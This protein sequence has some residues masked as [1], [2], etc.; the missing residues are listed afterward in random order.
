MLKDRF[1]MMAAKVPASAAAVMS[2]LADAGFEAYVVGGCVRDALLGKEPHDWDMTTN[3]TPDQMKAAVSFPSIDT[4]LKHG[5][6]TFVVDHEPIEVTTF[7]T[8]GAY[9]DGRHPDSVSFATRLEDDLSRR[10]FTVNAMAWSPEVGLVDPFGG[11]SDLEAKVL[12]CVGDADRRFSEDGLRVMR[13]LRF[14]AVYGFRIEEGTARAAHDKKWMLD[15]V[16][17]ERICTELTKMM[18]AP[19]GAHLASIVKE[20]ADVM[21]Q[22][23][24]ELEPTYGM[25]QQ[26]PHHDRDCWTHMVDTMA[27]VEADSTLRL[28]ALLHDVGKPVVKRVGPDGIAHY[29]G[30]APEGACIVEALLR[31]LKFPRKTID[32]VYFLVMQ[33]DSW[34]SPTKRSA[35]RFLARCGDEQTARK[36]LALMKADRK[37]HA[38]GSVSGKFA[39]LDD[40]EVLMNAELN[41]ETAFAVKDLAIGGAD[42]MERGWEEGPELGAELERL[43]GL[44]LADE[45]PNERAALLAALHEPNDT[46]P[47]R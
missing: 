12:R 38:P 16:S 44:V 18:A 14:A 24:P 2:E 32:E 21:M 1:D 19:D 10:D 22:I 36:L 40:F 23:M 17:A 29:K 6:V 42:L 3:A 27:D 37:A 30:H 35:R 11:A 39:E 26:N 43:F 31:R 45:L 41:E 33:H 46:V 13:A 34:P 8:D 28:T 5:T 25:D 4:G 7:R 47:Q 15:A 20:F 9:S